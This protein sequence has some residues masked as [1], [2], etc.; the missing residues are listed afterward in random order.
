MQLILLC[1]Q[2]KEEKFNLENK[3]KIVL[4]KT[5]AVWSD[6]AKQYLVVNSLFA[7]LF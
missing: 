4:L 6:M 1:N 7:F 3:R 5:Y 2:A